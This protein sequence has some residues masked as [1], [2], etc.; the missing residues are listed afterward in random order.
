M[1]DM[2]SGDGS[3]YLKGD[4]PSV[5]GDESLPPWFFTDH[6]GYMALAGNI[7]GKQ[8]ISPAKL[9]FLA[10]ARF[11]F[12]ASFKGNDIL[13]ADDI[14]PVIAKVRGNFPEEEGLYTGWFGKKAQGTTGFQLNLNVIKT[15]LVI[16]PGIETCNS[17]ILS[18]G[19]FH[20]RKKFRIVKP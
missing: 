4:R 17:H 5:Q 1:K 19:T 9:P 8:D 20:C 6:P 11:N 2:L 18:S 15:G 14:V 13:R 12:S 3:G 10:A 16:L 7:L